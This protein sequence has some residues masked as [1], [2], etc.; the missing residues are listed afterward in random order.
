MSTP[1]LLSDNTLR[2]EA[3]EADMIKAGSKKFKDALQAARQ[4]GHESETPYGGK[5]L[6]AS[7]VAVS[8]G[9]TAYIRAT[10]GTTSPAAA[11]LYLDMVS[12]DVAAYMA[13]KGVLDGIS[14]PKVRLQ[15]LATRIATLIEDDVRF[16]FF[17]NSE[18]VD[19]ETGDRKSLK[20][21]FR[22]LKRNLN[23][24]TSNYDHKRTVLVH[25]MGKVGLTW[26]AWPKA[27]KVLLGTKLIEIVIAT[28]SVAQ[29]HTV[30][31][32]GRPDSIHIAPTETTSKWIEDYALQAELM[33]PVYQPMVIPPV[34][35]DK[36][37]GGG[38]LCRDRQKLKLVKTRSKA[39][40]EELHATNLDMIYNA[41]NGM[42]NTPWKI[43][44]A[45]LAVMVEA[46]E[47]KSI[48]GGLPNQEKEPKPPFPMH[49]PNDEAAVKAWKRA[50]NAHFKDEIKAGSKRYQIDSIIKTAKKFLPEE[51]IYFPYTLD[52][53]GR[54]YAVPSGLQ[55]QGHDIAKG[56]LTFAKGKPLETQGAADWLAIHGANLFGY[57]KVSLKDRV[58]WTKDHREQ[59]L[60]SAKNPLDYLWW[61]EADGGKKA[62]QF[63]A[64]CFEWA[65]YR[66]QGLDFV[67]CLPIALDGSCNGLQHFSA[68]LR[69]PVGGA[70]VNLM[71]SDTPNDIYQAVCDLLME[72]LKRSNDPMA[73]N[74]MAFGI[75]RKTCKRPVMVVP[76]GGTRHSSRNYILE[77]VK[78]RLGNREVNPFGDDRSVFMHCT[79]LATLMWEAI[80]ETVV[81]ARDAMGWLQGVSQAVAK[82]DRPMNWKAPTGFPVQQA[83]AEMK[84]KIVKTQMAGMTIKLSLQEEVLDESEGAHHPVKLDKRRQ[85]SGISPNFV[86]SL[87][88][89]ALMFTVDAA[90][91]CGIEAFGMIHDSYATTAADTD[92]LRECLRQSFCQMYQMDV[93]EAFRQ[94]IQAGL[95]DGITLPDLPAKGT[96]DI[97]LVLESDFF[98]A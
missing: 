73:T 51:A 59:I 27:D 40:L 49:A 79:F 77:H 60:A 87:D 65:A 34:P 9:I 3:L 85:A 13:I 92:T 19:P 97:N 57:D 68:M 47:S 82:E 37:V 72:K 4:G 7:I 86:H 78:E 2:Q 61:A 58:K 75:S 17:E 67:S 66:E 62:W 76:Y 80:G 81:A 6:S 50:I 98:F 69:D 14:N 5:I 24:Q 33:C 8:A 12:A 18:Q 43:N 11:L 71:P 42:Q 31:S 56:L 10:K 20:A 29:L 28:T 91:A 21:L 32:R 84:S 36:P 38:Y 39:Y 35:W 41:V 54:V 25:S 55:P 26:L 90:L 74:W 89:A 44:A 64:F 96:L 23:A 15:T 94:E 30:T 22:V 70:A 16:T 63:L 1:A 83:Y 45:V 48:I 52:F 88:A 95:P 46:W 93:L 53:R